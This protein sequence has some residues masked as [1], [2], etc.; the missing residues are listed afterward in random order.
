MG[1][2]F[3]KQVRIGDSEKG[4]FPR[5]L[6]PSA[7][8][9]PGHSASQS[10]GKGRSSSGGLEGSGGP[11]CCLQSPKRR[12]E[13]RVLLPR[14]RGKETLWQVQVNPKPETAEQVSNI[15][16]I[17]YG[18][19]F[20]GKGPPTTEL[21]Y[22]LPGP[23][24]RVPA[25]THC[26]GVSGVS[27]ASDRLRNFGGAPTVPGLA[28]RSILLTPRV[29]KGPGGTNSFSASS[30]SG[31]NSVP[32]RPASFCSLSGTS[33]QGPGTNQK[34]PYGPRLAIKPGKIQSNTIAAHS[35]FRVHP[36][37]H[38][39]KGLPSI[40]E[41]SKIRKVS[42]C[43]PGQ[44][45]GFNQ[46]PDVNTRTVNFH[47]TGS[48]VGRD[49][50]SG[51][52]GLCTQ[53]LG[54]QLRTPRRSGTGPKSGK[55]IPLVVEK[56]HQS[57]T[58]SSMA[59]PVSIDRHHR[60]QRQRL[61]GSPGGTSSTG[62]L[63]SGRAET[64][65]QL[66]GA[67]GDR[68][69][70]HLLSGET[71]RTPRPS[72]VR[73]CVGRGLCKQAGWHQVCNPVGHNNK[74]LSLGRNKHPVLISSFS[75]G[76]R[77]QYSGFPQS[78]STEGRRVVPQSGGLPSFGQEMGVSGD[79]SL[80]FQ[81]EHKNTLVFLS[82]QGRGSKRD[83]CPIPEL[84]LRDLLRLPTPSSSATGPEKISAGEHLT[85]PC[86]TPLAQEGLVFGS[87]ATD[88]RTPSFS[89]SSRGSPLAGSSTVPSGTQMEPRGV[90]T[91]ESL[92]RSKGFSDKLT[93]TLLDSRKK[94]TRSIY[95]KVWIRFNTWCQEFSFPTQSHKS[96]LEFLQCGADKG[97]S[98]ST[99]KGQV[100]ALS[101]FLESPLASNPWVI[102][103]FRALSRQKPSQGPSFPKWDLSLVLQVLT[104]LPFEPL[105][106]CSLKDL[107]FKTVF[108]VA[109]T[110]A[111]RVSE[112]EALSIRPPFCV[113]FPDRVVFKTDPAFLPKV[114]SKFHRSQEVVLPS[115]C[116][117][118]SGEREFKF[119]TLD[120]RRCILQYLELTRAFR[121][122]DSLF[123]LFSGTRKG[124][125]ASRRTIAR[126]LRL[127][128]GQ[129]Y[130]LSGREVPTG[131]KAH[132]TRA[133]ATSQAERAGATPDQICKAATWSSYATFIKHYRVDLVSAGEQAFGRKVLQAVVPP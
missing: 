45:S 125:K 62:C 114:A 122:S 38:P 82:G 131:I 7:T 113:I 10:Q 87:Q 76:D 68:F 49:S 130:S 79:R 8:E 91:E 30:G 107:T 110:T 29:H 61:G 39:A 15:Q 102:R 78:K 74:N 47:S 117:N 20:H 97:L 90:V 3:P 85:Y 58:G 69:S 80:R 23:Q 48:P 106:K 24:G 36:G 70:S 5:V 59:Y 129:A 104:G 64:F 37:L 55:E 46:I 4:V 128:I 92:L 65:L 103:F 83:R 50:L 67:E 96:V 112:L 14:F 86:G 16:K 66:E 115:F 41:G 99:L 71:S 1:V 43:P 13:K 2:F 35:L 73:Q 94:E 26:R 126:W 21:L 77:K 44:P 98:V 75:K 93:A 28:I 133:V 127:V 54:P 111:R 34:D 17:P 132:S 101:V 124:Q 121:K 119:S 19:N 120:V 53:N 89:S 56:D 84:A 105:D 123:V 40:R 12:G 109:V 118:P 88:H 27:T 100:S 6:M 51:P 52:A 81:G 9:V 33:L 31:Y 22:G 116:S 60:R 57:V 72:E 25:R 18:V 32:G 11:K 42:I 108:L 95:R 63:G